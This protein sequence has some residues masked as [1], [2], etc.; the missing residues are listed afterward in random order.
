MDDC[1]IILECF[2]QYAKRI[3]K[4][5]AIQCITYS[6]S[7]G[8][9]NSKANK[10]AHYLIGKGVKRGDAV[11]LL[12]EHN[13]DIAIA[14]L[15]VAKTGG[16][17][18][19]LSTDFPKSKIQIIL[20]DCSCNIII[21]N[22]QNPLPI[23]SQIIDINNDKNYN[24]CSSVNPLVVCHKDDLAYILFTSGSTGKP[25]G[26]KI[27]NQNL[28]YYIDWYINSIESKH[29][30]QLPFTSSY[31]YAASVVQLYIPLVTGKCLHIIPPKISTNSSLLLDWYKHHPDFGLYIVP[32]LWEEH[33]LY[34][35]ANL[36]ELPGFLIITGEQLK[37]RLVS[38][39]FDY[40]KKI[41]IWNL[42]GP[43]ETVANITYTKVVKDKH[44][45]IGTPLEGSEAILLDENL[46]EVP[47]GETGEL[48]VSGPGVSPG[49]LNNEELNKRQF[50]ILEG[51][52]YYK[53]GDLASYMSDGLLKFHGR[54]DRQVKVNGVR[55][56]LE[57]IENSLNTIDDV[58]ES[59]VVLNS[60]GDYNNKLFAY[61]LTSHPKT[62]SYYIR[63]LSN[64]LNPQ[65]IPSLIF[66]LSS[67]PK[68]ANGKI[69]IKELDKYRINNSNLIDSK[70]KSKPQQI[71]INILI[72]LLDT[73]DISLDDN[74]FI[75]GAQSITIIKLVNRLNI[76]FNTDI[77]LVDVYNNP[78]V[79]SLDKFITNYSGNTKDS[80][81]VE[82]ESESNNE[83]GFYSLSINQKTLWVIDQTKDVG[84]AHN[85]I[86]GIKLYDNYFSPDKLGEALNMVIE[87][88]NILSSY[89]DVVDG[90]VVRRIRSNYKPQIITYNLS[91]TI[92]KDNII[93][94]LNT[95]LLNDNKQPPVRYILLTSPD[96]YEFIVIINHII[97][98]GYSINLF[99]NK[100]IHEYTNYKL[101]PIHDVYDYSHFVEQQSNNV[102]NEYYN[103]GLNYWINKLRSNSY[104]LDLP[105]DYV[106]PQEQSF[107]GDSYHVRIT[108]DEK[109]NI[110]SFCNS[111]EVSMFNFLISAYS[112]LLHKYSAQKDILISFPYANRNNYHYED[113]IGYFVNNVLF[114]SILENE[115]SFLDIVK[116]SKDSFLSDLNY[117]DCPIEL[118]YPKLNVIPDP[119]MNPLFQVMFA[120]H[121]KLE[122]NKNISGVTYSVE[123]YSNN[124]SKLDLFLEAQDCE[125]GILLKFNYNT[126]IFKKE[127]IQRFSKD[128]FSIIDN[129]IN[130]PNYKISQFS[131]VTKKELALLRDWNKTEFV[132]GK[133]LVF[134]KLFFETANEKPDN[135]A[136]IC[137]NQTYT[138]KDILDKVIAFSSYLLNIG[139]TSNSLVGVSI[140]P[141]IEMLVSLIAIQKVGAA[142]VPL[143]PVY[144]KAKIDYIISNSGL[145]Y[146]VSDDR[147]KVL[148]KN[149][150]IINA[151][152][153]AIKQVKKHN[154]HIEPEDTMYV[155]YTSGSTGKSKGVVVP[156]KG[157]TNYLLWMK[158]CFDIKEN[159]VFLYQTS[160]NFDISV[161]EMFLPLIS[162]A[163]VLILP[164][165]IRKTSEQVSDI[166]NKY[167]VS[168]V[169]F[170]PAALQAFVR[171][172]NPE[173]SLS[174]NKI[175]VGGEKLS[176]ELNNACL[177]KIDCG[178]INLYGPTE[179]SIFCTYS[180]CSFQESS[181][182]SIGK[183]IV[184]ASIHILDENF[185]NLPIGSKGEIYISGD[186]LA[187]GYYNNAKET[188]IRFV[189]KDV[190]NQI[191]F[192]T[193]DIGSFRSD[194]NIDFWGRTDR[195][196]K[197]RGYRLELTEIENILLNLPDI[198]NV[199]VIVKE[200][201]QSDKRIIAFYNQYKNKPELGAKKLREHTSEFLP[202][203]MIPSD[204]I[205]LDSIPTLPNGKTD[206]LSLLNI[207]LEKNN[208][209]QIVNGDD[210]SSD[211]EKKIR[212]IW[213]E[214]LGNKSFSI[215]DNFF[216]VGGHSLLL[217][218]VKEHFEKKFNKE[219]PLINFY[220]YTNISSLAKNFMENEDNLE[221]IVTI[222]ERI[223]NNKRK[224]S[225]NNFRK[226][227]GKKKT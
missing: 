131:L 11:A 100:L 19:P 58:R 63:Q 51:K 117:L 209:K 59:L 143:D 97:F 208:S 26:V 85:I 195:Q 152:I 45:S 132:F 30:G 189:K 219:I 186:I 88:N 47:F 212:T 68:L 120:Y 171:T 40:N 50:F 106:R 139:V 4:K 147:E 95:N 42:Y 181:N 72:D 101:F 140:K 69:N 20:N 44:I 169:Q 48:C 177:A 9:L 109:R 157:V 217:L 31:I 55:I 82:I 113:T 118:I 78:N 163:S 91:P 179:A 35:K 199:C 227:R 93:R 126:S 205:K 128:F 176:N 190:H 151:S 172:Y 28:K 112:I 207:E 183:P 62:S 161:W 21:S 164:R 54:K 108:S 52:R 193:G 226:L 94:S 150:N 37:E 61:V 103:E 166:I 134:Y 133:K 165:E 3:A 218:E 36:L 216:E 180:Y 2:E 5:K 27:S 188:G 8:D 146:I 12:L 32:T 225:N 123:E 33:L 79:R 121:E 10:L 129:I 75:I 125:N 160:I 154:H 210:N 92:R 67:F 1:S 168:I 83:A 142:Y 149:V 182:V 200:N 203:Y 60:N 206:T 6:I 116:K 175:F 73:K 191:M 137:E 213:E 159:D 84:H 86:F 99:A 115:N 105:T 46:I 223:A 66:A 156:N 130:L 77:N 65:L 153:P 145:K 7:Y 39:T 122:T 184:N 17:Y 174:I 110:Q 53:T 96:S 201:S 71:I 87:K 25:K 192:R 41:N 14:V 185:N 107:E 211:I 198:E 80:K 138:Y 64:N 197:I 173:H 111:N 224:I 76:V 204:F 167:K 194:G 136:V 119:S 24:D 18:V 127:R 135:I 16:Y 214:V 158:H 155:M 22:V 90:F 102:K 43:T 34:A 124:S 162:G 221:F 81:E 23:D 196:V 29:K 13:K 178:L 56:E 187:N 202:D 148:N 98:D 215:D 57:E 141:G 144:P 220:K 104:S 222:R 170:V 49:Y 38:E 70:S 74:F 89:F 114:N 15:A